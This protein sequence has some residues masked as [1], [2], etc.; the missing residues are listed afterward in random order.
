MFSEDT[1]TVVRQKEFE[2]QDVEEAIG[3]A[4]SDNSWT[5]KDGWEESSSDT[6][7]EIRDDLCYQLTD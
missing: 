7:C 1:K 3:M 4:E 5:E 6:S 2:A